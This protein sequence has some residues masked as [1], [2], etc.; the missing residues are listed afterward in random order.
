[1]DIAGNVVY[2]KMNADILHS[3]H[4]DVIGEAEKYGSVVVGVLTDK[5]MALSGREPILNF[6]QRASVFSRVKG[7]SKVVP[8]DSADAITNILDLQPTYVLHWDDEGKGIGRP[9]RERVEQALSG[10]GG[11]LIVSDQS[12]TGSNASVFE[13]L[14]KAY[15]RPH[16]RQQQL[17]RLLEAKSFVRVL[18]AHTPLC[19]L[20]IENLQ[21]ESGG[22]S[23]TF[24]AMWSSSLTDSTSKGKPDIEAVDLTSRLQNINDIFEVTTKPLIYDADTG[25]KPEHFALAVKS[26][27]RVGVSAVIIE[28]KTGLKKNSL[29]GNSVTQDQESIEAFCHKIQVGKAAC[30]TNDFMIIARI[31]SLILEKGM[32]DALARAKAYIA[33]GA[34]GIMIHSREKSPAEILE[35]CRHYAMF[36]E[37]VP[38]V[39]VPSSYNSIT[40]I[41]LSRAGVNIVIYA[42][43]MLR[44]SYPAM[45]RIAQSI[46]THGRSMECESECMPINEILDLIPGTR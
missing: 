2:V 16:S 40:D 14:N 29:F 5:A 33:A 28:D 25:G 22:E 43:H 36:D 27:E 19:G 35:F 6:E 24:D 1:M 10:W 44:A 13:R 23:R 37:R 34:D 18:E 8:Q 31:E 32:H 38:L 20:I 11:K 17:S 15:A 12:H 9:E 30:Q 41:E 7:V 21:V 26:L 4:I 3:G 46:L 39:A 42:N 45:S